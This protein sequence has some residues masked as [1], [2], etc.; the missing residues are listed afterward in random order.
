MTGVS[1]PPPPW[2]GEVD[3]LSDTERYASMTPEERLVC[4]AEVC[5]LARALLEER[6]DRREVLDR[7]EPLRPEA[8]ATWRRLVLE[9]RRARP[10]R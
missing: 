6:P 4:F 3:D 5:E 1:T 7:V 2:L 8:E 10:A 9:A